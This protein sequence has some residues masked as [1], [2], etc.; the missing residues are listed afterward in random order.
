MDR[1]AN[2]RGAASGGAILVIPL[3]V[4]VACGIFF[5][6]GPGAFLVAIDKA[7]RSWGL[8]IYQW[9]AHLF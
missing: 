1:D 9:A 2:R 8:A 7:I 5:S 4:L 3:V 6:G